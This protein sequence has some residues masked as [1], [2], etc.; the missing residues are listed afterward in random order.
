MRFIL[1][2]LLSII[3]SLT[4]CLAFTA[5]PARFPLSSIPIRSAV[6][7]DRPLR[8]GHGFDIHR[9]VEDKKLII[10][11][12]SYNIQCVSIQLLNMI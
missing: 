2:T 1:I 10:G 11:K 6:E 8:I 12:I 5:P 3:L 4:I 7:S 9:L